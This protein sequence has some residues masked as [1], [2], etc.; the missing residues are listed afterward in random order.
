MIASPQRKSHASLFRNLSDV[1]TSNK[2]H[3]EQIVGNVAPDQRLN[4]EPPEGASPN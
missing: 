4:S 2:V 1:G 3:A